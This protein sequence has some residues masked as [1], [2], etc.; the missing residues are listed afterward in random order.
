M[1]LLGFFARNS[2]F[3]ATQTSSDK[4]KFSRAVKD[5]VEK[6]EEP[7]MTMRKLL[8]ELKILIEDDDLER[9]KRA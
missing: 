9:S 4:E 3:K 7:G 5:S 2:F 1:I 8:M 6:L